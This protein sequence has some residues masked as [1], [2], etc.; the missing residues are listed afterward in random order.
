[1]TMM[2]LILNNNNNNNNNDNNIKELFLPHGRG[3]V[4]SS[5]PPF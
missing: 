5:N 2:I 1:M 4:M 3:L